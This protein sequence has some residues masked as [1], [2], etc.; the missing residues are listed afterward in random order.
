MRD[1]EPLTGPALL[2][3]LSSDL[4]RASFEFLDI[5]DGLAPAS[6]AAA[7]TRLA[8]RPLFFKTLLREF[9]RIAAEEQQKVDAV[10][11]GGGER[12]RLLELAARR[13]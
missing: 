11:G 5:G 1:M 6:A 3:L 8:A 12:E 13:R 4:V 10:P 2:G 7:E 9:P